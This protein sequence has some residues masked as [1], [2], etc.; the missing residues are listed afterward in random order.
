MNR[1]EKI[2]FFELSDMILERLNS[3][4]NAKLTHYDISL[5]L[6]RDTNYPSDKFNIYLF[7]MKST[8]LHIIQKT[9]IRQLKLQSCYLFTLPMIMAL[10][11]QNTA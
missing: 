10:K 5:K 2:D 6:C 3:E 8:A 4:G 7:L 9:A 11:I 1:P